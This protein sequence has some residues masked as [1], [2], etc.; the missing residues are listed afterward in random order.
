MTSAQ[1]TPPVPSGIE[2]AAPDSHLHPAG[3]VDA[4]AELDRTT[5]D[6]CYHNIMDADAT[7]IVLDLTATTFMDCGGYRAIV[8]ARNDLQ[9]TGSSLQLTGAAGEPARLLKLIA[10]L[11]HAA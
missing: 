9:R 2:R 3:V 11:Q 1:A 8:A 10:K 5:S 7:H 6:D 4:P